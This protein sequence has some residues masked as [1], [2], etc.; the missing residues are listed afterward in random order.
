M[1]AREDADQVVPVVLQPVRISVADAVVLAMI[2]ALQHVPRNVVLH[3][4]RPVHRL[5]WEW[6]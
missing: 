2:H 3:A 5:A 1:I 6:S 4:T